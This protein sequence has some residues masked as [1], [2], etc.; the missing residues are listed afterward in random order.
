MP[1]NHNPTNNWER[2][3]YDSN[4]D[5]VYEYGEAVVDLL[6]PQPGERVLDIGCGTGH[7]TATIADRGADVLG[8]DA[9]GEMVA[10]ARETYPDLDFRHAD[11]RTFAPE[12]QFDAV[13]SNAAIHWIPDDDQDAMLESVRSALVPDGR[14]VAEMGG[15]GN[16]GQIEAATVD[17]LSERGYDVT[18]PWYFPGIGEYT[19]RIESH[20]FEV[21]R[22]V[23]FDRPTELEDGETGLENWLGM[24][25]DSIFDGVPADEQAA[26]IEAVEDRLRDD[27]FDSETGTWT[28]DYRRLRFVAQR[29]D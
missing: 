8:I 12:K 27:L 15:T 14:F 2:D 18:P 22:A 11:A 24:F 1:D 20:G 5:F 4:H 28:A 6:D 10:G 26:V 19:P 23:L 3:D 21:T 13:F 7:L 29:T 25:G 9:S 17:V 16:V